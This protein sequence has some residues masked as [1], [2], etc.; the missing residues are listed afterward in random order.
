M[1]EDSYDF[2]EDINEF[3]NLRLVDLLV[4]LIFTNIE[5]HIEE[6]DEF[7]FKFF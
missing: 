4:H 5:G 2:D 1:W 3:E 7:K 6:G